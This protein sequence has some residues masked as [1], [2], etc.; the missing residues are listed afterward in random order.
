MLSVTGTRVRV[1]KAYL[2]VGVSLGIV[3]EVD[4]VIVTSL[5]ELL[6]DIS[7]LST[8][9]AIDRCVRNV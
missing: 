7:F 4:T 6:D 2:S 8:S 5:H 1:N 3:K 9:D